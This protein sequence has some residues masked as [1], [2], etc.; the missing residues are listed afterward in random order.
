MQSTASL[1]AVVKK[2]C[3]HEVSESCWSRRFTMEIV[4][5]SSTHAMTFSRGSVQR[6]FSCTSA[7]MSTVRSI[8]VLMRMRNS[9]EASLCSCSCRITCSRSSDVQHDLTSPVKKAGDTYR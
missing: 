9:P 3:M 1:G 7:T 2:S 5:C 6:D 8:A 4:F